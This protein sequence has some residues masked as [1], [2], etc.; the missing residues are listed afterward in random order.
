MRHLISLTRQG[1]VT[2]PDYATYRNQTSQFD[3]AY[4][5]EAE[6]VQRVAN[7]GHA[8]YGVV[9]S[10]HGDWT[11]IGRWR[12]ALHISLLAL[13][14]DSGKTNPYEAI[15]QAMWCNLPLVFAYRT[16]SHT[17][18]HPRFRMVFEAK[19]GFVS[20]ADKK[21]LQLLN[22][23]YANAADKQALSPI[24]RWQ[25]SIDGLIYARLRY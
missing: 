7:K 3:W 1:Y 8:F 21:A 23:F 10:N 20:K 2:K 24:Q 17:E 25:G 4:I 16:Y 14:F 13:D 11:E 6:L 15:N 12:S 22:K 9:F 19:P 18:S 5:E